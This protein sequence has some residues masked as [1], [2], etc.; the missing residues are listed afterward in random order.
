MEMEM[1]MEMETGS[2]DEELKVAQL[3]VVLYN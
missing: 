3:P 2:R 1:E